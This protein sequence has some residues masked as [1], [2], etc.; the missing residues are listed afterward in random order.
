MPD[1]DIGLDLDAASDIR[2]WLCRIVPQ[3]LSTD[4]A[5]STDAASPGFGSP[6]PWSRVG[7]PAD[8]QE[9][10]YS[11]SSAVEPEPGPCVR[12]TRV[13]YLAGGPPTRPRRRKP[14]QG[15]WT[16]R[17]TPAGACPIAGCC[18][19]IGSLSP[20]AG[21]STLSVRQPAIGA[22]S[23]GRLEAGCV[24]ALPPSCGKGAGGLSCARSEVREAHVAPVAGCTKCR[25]V[26]VRREV[27]GCAGCARCAVSELRGV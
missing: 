10:K 7:G 20:K 17:R 2:A 24:A 11:P 3:R 19:D 18:T 1:P 13:Y 8:V 6:P 26:P 12:R 27:P 23:R 21:C 9:Q 5:A 16:R 25:V 4:R 22:P 15:Q 14:G